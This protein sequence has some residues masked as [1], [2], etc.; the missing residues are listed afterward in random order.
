MDKEKLMELQ[1][2]NYQMQHLQQQINTMEEQINEVVNVQNNLKEFGKLKPGDE[3]LV[4]VA[5]G[6]FAEAELKDNKKIRLNVGSDVVA[7]KTVKQ[8]I[9][10]LDK[11]SEDIIKTHNQAEIEFNKMIEK[12]KKLQ[13]NI[14]SD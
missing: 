3:I 13:E 2:L 6:M 4:P 11:H 12:A 7:E 5:N 10:L 8:A 9:Q 14:E 1:M